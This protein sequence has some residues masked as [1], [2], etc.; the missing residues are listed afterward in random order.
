MGEKTAAVMTISPLRRVAASGAMIA[1]AGML[2]AIAVSNRHWIEGSLLAFSGVVAAAGVGLSRRSMVSQVLSRAMGW[3]VFA[4]TVLIA[5]VSGASGGHTEWAAVALAAATGGA[6]LLSRPML[7][8]KEAQADFAPTSY[9]RW[10][11]AS[12]TASASAGMTAGMIALDSMRWGGDLRLSAAGLG[13]FGASLLGSAIGVV[14]M[15]AWGM[16]LG[17]ATSLVSLLGALLAHDS[18]SLAWMLAAVPGLM[19]TLPILLAARSRAR[20]ERDRGRVRVAD[21][22]SSD[23]VH[24]RYRIA[25]DGAERAIDASI[26]ADEERVGAA[27][28]KAARAAQIA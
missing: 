24:A 6:L 16:L 23:F 26:D 12:A 14:R 27:P 20:T 1:G 5:V 9:R 3:L 7:H 13:L 25:D 2:G 17:A 19:M 4:P 22:A 18:S 8:T 21:D 11:F 28:P 10:L 15:R